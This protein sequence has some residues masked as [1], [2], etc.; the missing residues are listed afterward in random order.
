MIVS[1][2]A[3]S[4]PL[5]VREGALIPM[6]VGEPVDNRIDLREV[7][8]HVFL[9]NRNGAK[10]QGRYVADDGESVPEPQK[11]RTCVEWQAVVEPT[12][13]LQISVS[14]LEKGF[15]AVTVRVVTYSPFER[16]RW[17]TNQGTRSPS[18]RPYRW[19]FTG[20]GLRAWRTA[21]L[22]VGEGQVDV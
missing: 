11:G 21:P 17:K 10:G 15:G 2:G 5:W 6:T 13:V 1:A 14:V 9:P 12:G 16:I 20:K 3:G 4:T 7:E 8:L 22:S 19:T 18:S